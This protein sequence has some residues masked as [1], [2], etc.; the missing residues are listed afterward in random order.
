MD[1][2]STLARAAP[3]SPSSV[4]LRAGSSFSHKPMR[5]KHPCR[6]TQ[7]TECRAV[8]W[9]RTTKCYFTNS[10]NGVDMHTFFLSLTH[11][12]ASEYGCKGV[13]S[14]PTLKLYSNAGMQTWCWTI[15][16]ACGALPQ[17][18]WTQTTPASVRC[19]FCVVYYFLKPKYICNIRLCL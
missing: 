12:M 17:R 6:A 15:T 7:F 13:V 5:L 2:D 10:E 19:V 18:T 16:C 8:A 1:L 3:V 9:S 14:I 11:T 4:V